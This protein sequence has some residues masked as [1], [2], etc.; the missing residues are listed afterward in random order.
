MSQVLGDQVLKMVRIGK[1]RRG[2][3]IQKLLYLGNCQVEF[4]SNLD[5]VYLRSVPYH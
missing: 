4:T 3:G 1:S 5:T 2:V